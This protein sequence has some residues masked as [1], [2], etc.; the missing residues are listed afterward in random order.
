MDTKSIN[1]TEEYRNSI[2]TVDSEGKRIWLYPKKPRGPWTNARTYVSWGLLAVLFGLPWVKINGNPLIRLD[3]ISRDFYLFGLH[4]TPQ[5]FYLAVVAMLTLV[6][7]IALFTVVFGRLFCGWVCP[8]TIFMEMVFR[9]IEYW[10]EG[11]A[12]AQRKLAAPPWTPEKIRKKT[13]KQVLFVLVA[14]VIAH[15]FLS[16]LIGPERVF[17]IITSS[18]A[19]NWGGF[20]AMVGF[21]GAF[22]FVFASLREQVCTTICPYGRLQ[23][24]LTDNDTILVTY[25]F[26][27]GEP[28]GKLKRSKKDPV[29][30][31]QEQLAHSDVDIAD[32]AELPLKVLGDCIDCSLCVQVCPTGIDIRDGVQLECVNCTACMDACDEVM[33]KI[34]RPERLIRYDS[35]NGVVKQERKIFTPRAIAYSAALLVLVV[36]N[37]L[38][39][40]N[41]TKVEA[42]ILRTPGKLYYEPDETHFSNLYNYQLFNKTNE[43]FVPAFRFPKHPEAVIQ[44]IGDAPVLTPETMAQGAFFIVLPKENVT[45]RK[46]TLT[47][48]LWDGDELLETTTTNFLGPI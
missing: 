24:V 28:R 40:S 12:N 9:K 3:I 7:F 21:T 17:T 8:Q 31:M 43:D 14:V 38:L 34:G 18:P 13:I 35:Y 44:F 22:Y 29:K 10:I 39:F 23:G 37:V 45:D 11:D 16:Y 47:I 42:V 32:T 30:N 27:R 1:D 5:D 46:Q 20:A 33:I 19:D 41:R 2:N 48:E 26:V 36:V 4:F 6:V 15:T 25:D